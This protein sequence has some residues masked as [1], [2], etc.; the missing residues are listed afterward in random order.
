MSTR[1]KKRYSVEFKKD[2]VALI[3][4]SDKSVSQISR[5]MGIHESQL[6]KWRRRYGTKK[7]V[8][9]QEMQS[10]EDLEA[11][12]KRLKRELHRVEQERDILKKAISIFSQERR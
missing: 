8:S 4:N 2:T 7:D 11:E 3:E 12:N 5:E 1:T 9:S 10:R 6:Y